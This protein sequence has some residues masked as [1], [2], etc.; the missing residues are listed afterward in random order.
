MLL[1][2]EEQAQ[3]K[4]LFAGL[5]SMG[6]A[7]RKTYLQLG[8][9]LMLVLMFLTLLKFNLTFSSMI[10]DFF[11]GALIILLAIGYKTKLASLVLTCLLTSLNFYFNNWWSF[12]LDE[13]MRDFLKYDFF[14]MLSV[15][16]GLLLV[17]SLGPGG[18]SV[19]EHKKKW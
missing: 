9:R 5:P 4:S 15:I 18:Y 1:L 11:G 2:A 13:T 16:G 8:G 17:I 14:Q 3:G 6:E 7:S 12:G 10:I 19:D